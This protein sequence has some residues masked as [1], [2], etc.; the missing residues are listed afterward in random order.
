MSPSCLGQQS[1]VFDLRLRG[2]PKEK[3]RMVPKRPNHQGTNQ[4]LTN[5]CGY[6][7]FTLIQGPTAD[8]LRSVQEEVRHGYALRPDVHALVE[9]LLHGGVEA[10]RKNCT[11][12]LGVPMQPML[13][14]A[15]TSVA[16]LL[17]R[18]LG[19]MPE[20]AA[21]ATLAAEYKYDG[22][23][24]QIHILENGVVKIFSRKLD[25][26][27]Y[28]YPDVVSVIRK[29]QRAKAACVLD[30]EIATQLSA[31]VIHVVLHFRVFYHRL[32]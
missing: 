6:L 24:A 4:S 28:K 32:S 2:S 13:A 8:A 16:E 7:A 17:K 3:R 12:Q 22:Q 30:A 14:K 19:S 21:R 26:M 23:R 31:M 15:C 29:A 5:S 27:T 9:S 10:V 18:I 1:K 20:K 11:L 25:D